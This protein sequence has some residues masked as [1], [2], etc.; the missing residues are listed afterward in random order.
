M[1]SG[2][3]ATPR[4]RRRLGVV[5]PGGNGTRTPRSA[6]RSPTSRRTGFVETGGGPASDISVRGTLANGLAGRPVKDR[7]G[8]PPPGEG[9]QGGGPPTS[10]PNPPA[11][12]KLRW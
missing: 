7:A 10:A 9:S 8:D 12:P 5:S 11:A 1:R 3:E 6:R 2:S 4:V